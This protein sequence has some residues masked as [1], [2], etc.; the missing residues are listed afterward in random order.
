[1]LIRGDSPDLGEVS[2]SKSSRSN[3]SGDCLEVAYLLD[4]VG[5]RDSK[6]PDGPIL[7]FSRAEWAAFIAGVKDGRFE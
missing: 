2:W 3:A 7:T 5:V 6:N 4:L 1:M